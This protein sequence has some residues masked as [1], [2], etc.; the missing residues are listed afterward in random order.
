[1][2]K[3]FAAFAALRGDEDLPILSRFHQFVLPVMGYGNRRVSCSAGRSYAG[4]GP[5]GVLYPCMRFVGVD[6]YS[7]GRVPEGVDAAAARSFRLGPGRP[8]DQRQ[9]CSG[10]WA[11]PL[12]CGPCYACSEMFGP[13]DGEPIDYQCAYRLAAAEAAVSLFNRLKED[14]PERLLSLIHI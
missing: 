14:N 6:R 12:C 4:V 2:S 9:P 5:D 10:C 13:G 3:N 1:M 8:Y 7:I 11:A